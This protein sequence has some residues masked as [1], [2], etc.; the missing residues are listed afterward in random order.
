MTDLSSVALRS[1]R[2]YPFCS[3]LCSA[4]RWNDTDQEGKMH[5]KCLLI[6]KANGVFNPKPISEFIL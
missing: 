5:T 1:H 6:S 3:L 4:A 2:D